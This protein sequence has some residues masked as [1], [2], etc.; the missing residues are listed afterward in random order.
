[1]DKTPCI[2]IASKPPPVSLISAEVFFM[3]IAVIC[4]AREYACDFLSTKQTELARIDWLSNIV[5]NQQQYL[6]PPPKK[7]SL[8]SDLF[9][10]CPAVVSFDGLLH[11]YYS[12]MHE[13]SN[14]LN[15]IYS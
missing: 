13:V 11:D 2:I 1:V 3:G 7:V 9:N 15:V 14:G 12:R 4:T 10:A 5:Y 8:T 6:C